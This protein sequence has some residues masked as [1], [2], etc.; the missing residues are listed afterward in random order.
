MISDE[1]LLRDVSDRV[2]FRLFSDKVLLRVLN[3]RIHLRFPSD[4]VL[5]R[6]LGPWMLTRIISSFFS[7]CHIVSHG[8]N[9]TNRNAHDG[10][11]NY[12][13]KTLSKNKIFLNSNQDFNKRQTQELAIF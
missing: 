1:I 13:A 12:K 10:F 11:R 4:R 5:L 8:H 3:E 7:K 2:F 9:D 6:V